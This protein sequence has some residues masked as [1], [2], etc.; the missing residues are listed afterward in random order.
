[1]RIHRLVRTAASERPLFQLDLENEAEASPP[2][3]GRLFIDFL[4]TGAR[5]RL[6]GWMD[7]VTDPCGL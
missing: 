2:R 6:F 3:A 4:G 1:M 5:P 7:E